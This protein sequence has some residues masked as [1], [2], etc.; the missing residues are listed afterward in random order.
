M[1]KVVEK[2]LKYINI[3]TMSDEE[4]TSTPS[5]SIQLNLAKVLV[6]ELHEL[7]IDNAYLDEYGLVYAYL[8]GEN[9]LDPI[10]LIA[11]MDTS[12]ELAGGNYTPRIIKNY[13][14]KDIKLNETYTM[15]PKEFP[16][17]NG[18]I[19]HDIIVT[20]G[21]HLLG[22]DDK[23]GV[24]IIME[25]ME[26]YVTHKD[27]KHAPIRICF[28]PDEEVGRGSENF[29]VEKMN[30]KV[31]YTLDGGR[32]NDINYENFNAYSIQVNIKG[33][34]IHPGSAK[35]IMVNSILVA[36]EFNS[37][38]PNETPANTEKYEGFAHLNDIRGT[39]EE[40][41]MFYIIRDHDSNKIHE[42]VGKFFE[43][44]RKLSLK[45]PKAHI[46]VI[47]KEGYHNM[48]EYFKNDMTAVNKATNAYK[49]LGIEPTYTPIRGGTD[50]ASI[51]FMSLPC[52]NL[53]TGDY[54]C[55]GRYE[56]V[57]INEMEQMVEVIKV[58]LESK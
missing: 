50:G 18:N 43:I 29:K 32:F 6:E 49:K 25:I 11:H 19:G 10:G 53:G 9:T 57:D 4:S 23:A 52:P 33:V 35:N 46:E 58:L 40:T 27:I 30:A 12:P 56:Y 20:D 47:S 22:G 34:G 17:L 54:N 48:Y 15:S 8:D 13:D 24:A 42:R 21:N 44:E 7:G 38:L 28:T 51:T 3:D 5:T 39:V 45:Y 37:L 1:S 41:N 26:Y 31:A 36:Q 2:F 16:S 14:G 55:H